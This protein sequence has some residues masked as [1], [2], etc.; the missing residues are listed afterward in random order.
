[1][2]I[3]ENPYKDL[4]QS[5]FWRHAVANV[6]IETLDPVIEGAFTISSN[7]KIASAG[8][9]FA[10]HIAR[11]LVLSGF[12]YWVAEQ[13]HP[14][15]P[16]KVKKDFNY[17]IYSARYGNI[18]TARQLVQL[19]LQASGEF[20]P[21]DTHWKAKGG[22]GFVDPYRPQIQPGGFDTVEELLADR[23]QHLAA[24]KKMFATCD[25]FFFTLGL[26]ESWC[27]VSDGA[28]YPLSP[29]VAG[30]TFHA[31]KH[32][33]VNFTVA[34]VIADL[35][36]F[37]DLIRAVNP[38]VRII[39][40]VSP[41]PLVATAESSHVLVSNTYSK[42]VLRVAADSVS[43]SRNDVVYFPSYEIITGHFN[44]GKYFAE[45]LRTV[46]EEGVS[47]VMRV[48]MKHFANKLTD[49]SVYTMPN[50]SSSACKSSSFIAEIQK[51]VEVQCDEE[52]LDEQ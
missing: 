13:A 24:V 34:E 40:T 26:T 30:G 42:S 28:I 31:E 41:V 12:N 52:V 47:H 23:Q 5:S 33:F 32:K 18:Y 15:L 1:M 20:I 7:D 29:G 4:P 3:S 44:R 39:L 9:C 17:G 2:A 10:Q 25:V 11:Y 48:F 45:D 22:Q 43:R 21:S 51:I 50:Y 27:N 46:T 19:F 14:M 36:V 38:S 49:H 35:T 37:V 6:S 8:S 16:A